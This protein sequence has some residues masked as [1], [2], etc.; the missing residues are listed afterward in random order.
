MLFSS[1]KPRSW[2]S[3]RGVEVRVA[4]T[5][6]AVAPAEPNAA[7]NAEEEQGTQKIYLGQGR[8]IED[9][10]SKYPDK[11]NLG[12]GGWAGG[13]TGVRSTLAPSGDK[14]QQRWSYIVRLHVQ[15]V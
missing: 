2:A 15:Y 6:Q 7:P 11:D 4:R 9:D 10:P 14:Q 1:L 3:G 13:E 5:A 8:F 12:V